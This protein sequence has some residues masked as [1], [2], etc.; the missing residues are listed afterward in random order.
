MEDGGTAYRRLGDSESRNTEGETSTRHFSAKL[1][2]VHNATVIPIPRR[3]SHL[4]PTVSFVKSTSLPRKSREHEH[5]VS[6]L[7]AHGIRKLASSS[8]QEGE[9]EEEK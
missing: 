4:S 6:D 8:I 9:E 3:K 1:R 2:E 5:A 7:S